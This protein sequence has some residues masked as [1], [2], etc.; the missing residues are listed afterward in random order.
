MPHLADVLPRGC[1]TSVDDLLWA[2]GVCVSR[3]FPGILGAGAHGEAHAS[4]TDEHGHVVLTQT[5][6]GMQST[7]TIER[8]APL[9][10][11]LLPLFDILNHR[12]GEPLTLTAVPPGGA[13]TCGVRFTADTALA[14]GAELYNNYSNRSNEE[15]LFCYGFCVRDNP[16]DGASILIGDE[17]HLLRRADEGG[18]VELLR[19]LVH[20][21]A[22]RDDGEGE[23]EDC[24]GG[25][26]ERGS[27]GER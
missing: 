18:L 16:H 15:L 22:D 20:A 2:R 21:D 27:R 7:Q 5:A 23:G 25:E 24:E 10:G 9:P 12:S 26:D 1:L 11:C 19:S 3:A 17:H 4:D 14:A 8:D 13:A 6:D